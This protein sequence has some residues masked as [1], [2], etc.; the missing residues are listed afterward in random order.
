MTSKAFRRLLVWGVAVLGST[1][2]V[3]QPLPPQA[4]IG[5][6]VA[7]LALVE[8]AGELEGLQGRTFRLSQVTLAPAGATPLHDHTGRPEIIYV[9]KGRLT[10]HRG[11]GSIVYGP[12]ETLKATK[13]TRHWIENRTSEPVIFLAMSIVKS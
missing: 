10:E 13:D 6:V 8:L 9:V 1:G 11:G 3:A 12:G 4:A 7:P 5:F 2:S